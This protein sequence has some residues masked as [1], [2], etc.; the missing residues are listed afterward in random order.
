M[1]RRAMTIDTTCHFGCAPLAQ[2]M[3]GDGR[4]AD[5]ERLYERTLAFDPGNA[6]V[7]RRYAVV[8]MKEGSFDRAVPHLQRVAAEFPTEEHLVVLGAAQVSVGLLRAGVA[9]LQTAARLYPANQT[10]TRLIGAV[11]SETGGAAAAMRQVAL[12]L[13]ANWE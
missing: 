12:N 1:F 11:E 3:A 10:I 6:P 2:L 9:T 8:L 5:A 13:S 4:S 7:E